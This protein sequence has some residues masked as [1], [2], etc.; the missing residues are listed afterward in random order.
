MDERPLAAVIARSTPGLALMRGLRRL[1]RWLRLG[2]TELPDAVIFLDVAPETA[3]ARLIAKGAPLD[4]HENIHDLATARTMYQGVAELF[5]RRCGDARVAVIDVTALSL[6]EVIRRAVAFVRTLPLHPRCP[7]RAR[8]RLGTTEQELSRGSAVLKKVLSY[9][10]LVRYALPNLHRGSTHELTFPLSSLGRQLLRDGYSAGMMRAI[11][12]QE[13]QRYG[14]LDRVCLA[15]PLHR[16]V[17]HRLLILRRAIKQE[18]CR[19]LGQVS[20][21]AALKILTAPSGYAFDL[22]QPLGRL[23]SMSRGAH[24]PLHILASDLDP[25]GQ[26]EAALRQATTRCS[27]RRSPHWS[28]SPTSS[29]MRRERA[30]WSRR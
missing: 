10:Y 25:D 22:F 26:I 6:G 13:G 7:A 4:Q 23:A 14:L 8:A 30:R 1:D 9:R 20:S 17:Y 11:Y 18:L 3:L 12:L 15:Y 19:R 5:R 16:A 28:T 27:S 29:T 2:L 24:L 21:G